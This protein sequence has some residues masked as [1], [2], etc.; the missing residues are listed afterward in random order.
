MSWLNCEIMMMPSITAMPNNAMKPIAA[1]TLKGMPLSNRPSTPPNT[2]IGI[3]L[4]ASSVS[5]I[6]PK[7]NHS[8]IADQ[9]EADRHHDGEATYGVLQVAEFADPL[10]PRACA[11]TAPAR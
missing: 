7:L 8:N 1:D 10:Q 2:A 6:E 3:T 11:A 5:T 9:R 4:M